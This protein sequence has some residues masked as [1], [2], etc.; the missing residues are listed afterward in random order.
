MST[1]SA[2]SPYATAEMIIQEIAMELIASPGA[3]FLDDFVLAA[4]HAMN[5]DMVLISRIVSADDP[6]QAY[7]LYDRSERAKHYEYPLQK[8][9]CEQVFRNHAPFLV[10]EELQSRFPGDRDLEIFDLHS[11]VGMPL[12]R[13]SQCIGLIAAMWAKPIERP[14]RFL[15]AFQVA[16]PK[17]VWGINQMEGL[18]TETDSLNQQLDA[19]RAFVEIAESRFGLGTFVYDRF[20]HTLTLNDNAAKLLGLPPAQVRIDEAQFAATV[21]ELDRS[22]VSSELERHNQDQ[23]E[24]I[25]HFQTVLGQR[26]SLQIASQSGCSDRIFGCLWLA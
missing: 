5:A 4:G 3:R 1:N 7:A 12:F 9:P 15:Y 14:E 2:R 10:T 18:R 21:S 19:Q 26:L 22:A 16:E 23:S 13:G 25:V 11:Y 20:K 6:V 17:L 8:T 24:N